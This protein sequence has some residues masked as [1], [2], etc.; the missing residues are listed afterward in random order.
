MSGYTTT[1]RRSTLVVLVII[2]VITALLVGS[3]LPQRH[4]PTQANGLFR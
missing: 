4:Y 3:G 2:A 1:R